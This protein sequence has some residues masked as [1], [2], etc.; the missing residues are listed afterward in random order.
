MSP[1]HLQGRTIALVAAG[2]L[3]G[4]PA[5]YAISGALPS[6]G[7]GFPTATFVTNLT[8]ALALGLLLEVLARRGPDEGTRRS[9][10]LLVGTGILGAYTT[11]ST[12]SVDT[13]QLLRSHRVGLAIAYALGSVVLGVVA[14]GVGVAVGAQHHR[15]GPGVTDAGVDPDLEGGR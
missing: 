3:V 6:S 11:Y 1:L 9:V 14:T 10:R 4:A 2:G 13:D 5:R 15:G 8:G 12:F 7:S